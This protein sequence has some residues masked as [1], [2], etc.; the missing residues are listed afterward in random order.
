MSLFRAYKYFYYR[1]YS[2]NLRTWGESDAPHFNALL[3]ISFLIYLN[4]YAV[5]L[6]IDFFTGKSVIEILN[7]GKVKLGLGMIGIIIINSFIFLRNNQYLLIAKQF[8][9]ESKTQKKRRF[10]L[11]LAYAFF[12]FA[13]PIAIAHF[14]SPGQVKFIMK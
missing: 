14:S 9:E 8:V 7:V 10:F 12:S 13:L 4:F 1:I 2:W 5:L 11:C 3:G 6:A